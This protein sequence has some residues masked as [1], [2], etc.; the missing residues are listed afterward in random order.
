MCSGQ[1]PHDPEDGILGEASHAV[2]GMLCVA[3]SARAAAAERPPATAPDLPTLAG[4]ITSLTDA[5]NLLILNS[6]GV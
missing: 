3:C 1:G 4:Q 2:Q 5:V 6:L